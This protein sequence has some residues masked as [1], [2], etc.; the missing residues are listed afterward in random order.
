MIGGC[1]TII[2]VPTVVVVVVIVVVI[3]VV[4]VDVTHQS[5]RIAQM[6]NFFE[7]LLTIR[8]SDDEKTAFQVTKIVIPRHFGGVVVVVVVVVLLLLLF[9]LR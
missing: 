9:L 1:N 3:V 5:R 2:L 6:R 8:M 4:M 7:I